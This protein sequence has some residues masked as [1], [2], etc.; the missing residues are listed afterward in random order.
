M[1]NVYKLPDSYAKH[2]D[3]NNYKLLSINDQSIATLKKDINDVL[4]VLDISNATGKTLDLYGD[5]VGQQRGE[6]NDIQ[7]RY[8]I[9]TKLGIN[10][11]QGSY[12]SVLQ[13]ACRIFECEP[14]DIVIDDAEDA[15]R[16]VLTKFPLAVLVN[17]GFSSAQAIQM[18]DA[19]LPIGVTIGSSNFEG[20]FEFAETYGEYDENAGF[21]D[22]AQ[23]IGG[24]LGLLADTDGEETILPL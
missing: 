13:V 17:A 21:G 14:S 8:M 3:S 6:L 20:S 16:V 1:N 24:W 12:E 23:T 9:L 18:I 2:K 22:I 4:N 5:M 10:I 7:Y 19:L 15:C 11:T